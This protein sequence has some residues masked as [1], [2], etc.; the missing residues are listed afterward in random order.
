MIMGQ[1]AASSRLRISSTTLVCKAESFLGRV[2]IKGFESGV[3]EINFNATS[4]GIPIYLVDIS[5]LLYFILMH[6]I[7]T[8]AENNIALLSR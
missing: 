2:V 6:K 1:F 8:L 5:T 3:E 4:V 7:L